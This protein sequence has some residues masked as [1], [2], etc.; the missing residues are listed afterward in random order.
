M[1]NKHQSEG[2]FG[3]RPQTK[4]RKFDSP[5]I[6]FWKE[7]SGMYH[8]EISR[9]TW[10]WK[11]IVLPIGFTIYTKKLRCKEIETKYPIF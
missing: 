10:C 11:P 9:E 1:A 4:L 5:R 8:P 3:K 6:H 2:D 7:Y